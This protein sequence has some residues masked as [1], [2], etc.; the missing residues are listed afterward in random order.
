MSNIVKH[1]LSSLSKADYTFNLIDDNDRIAVGVSGGKDSM[2]LLKLLKLYQNFNNKNFEIYPIIIDLGFGNLELEK[3]E[4]YCKSLGLTLHVE[5]SRDV[6][7]I[8]QAHKNKDNH[9]PCSICSRM[10]KAAINKAAERLSCNKVSFAHHF[11]D[12]IETLIMNQIYGGRIATF[13]PKMHLERANITFIR[14]LILT[15]EKDIIKGCNYLNIPI[16]KSKCPN[17]KVT[18]REEIKTLLNSIYSKYK[19]ANINFYNMMLDDVHFDMWFSKK[20]FPLYPSLS[21]KEASTLEEFLTI[22]QKFNIDSNNF[23]SSKNKLFYVFDSKKHDDNLI[24]YG[25][26]SKEGKNVYLEQIKTIDDSK[27]LLFIKYFEYYLPLKEN[28]ITFN[29]KENIY[30]SYQDI[31]S[32]LN[33]QKKDG[34]YQKTLNYKPSYKY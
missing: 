23:L 3:L 25:L 27:V 8:L 24:L 26:I 22:H 30:S 16:I 4:D 5:D 14:P 21:I 28:P 31:F 19:E 12:A 10:K 29:I 9:L 7:T 2:L 34:S 15:K 32:S 17:D 13:S 33:Y 11:D 1:L 20:E 18:M 6:Y